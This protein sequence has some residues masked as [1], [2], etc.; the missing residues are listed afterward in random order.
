[1]ISIFIGA[2]KFAPPAKGEQ[3][4]PYDLWDGI[5]GNG[6]WGT[7]ADWWIEPGDNIFHENKTI[8]VNGNLYVNGS[9]TLTNVTLQMR[10]ATYDG[11]YNI[12]VLESGDLVI[13]DYDD[14]RDTASDAS[15]VES[16]TAFRFGFQAYPGS[17]LEFKNSELYDCGWTAPYADGL[18]L[19]IYTD[20]ANVTGNYINDSYYGTVIWYS[21]NV[22]L[23]NNT[24]DGPYNGVYTD[25]ANDCYL[26]NN[27]VT[28]I[29]NL[30]FFIYN[31]TML[32]L[33]YNDII[34][35][36]NAY[37][38]LVRGGGGHWIYN[39]TFSDNDLGVFLYADATT[40]T[41]TTSWCA[42][43]DNSITNNNYGVYIRGLNGDSAIQYIY[44]YDNDIYS[45]TEGVHIRGEAETLSVENIVHNISIYN[46]N[47]YSNS[48]YGMYL[49][50]Y[51]GPNV[52]NRVHIFENLVYDNGGNGGH[53]I[54]FTVGMYFGDVSYIYCWDNEVRDNHNGALN[55][56]AGYYLNAVSNIYFWDDHIADNDRNLWVVSSDNVYATNT[57]LD[58]GSG[59][60]DIDIRIDDRYGNPPSVYFL[61]TSFDNS[62]ADVYNAGSFLNVQWYLHVRVMQ[63][64]SGVD[65]ADVFINDSF[66]LPEPRFGQPLSTGTG[67]DGWIRWIEVTEFNRT[68][69]ATTR[70]TPHHID[71]VSLPSSSYADPS[72]NMSKEVIIYLNSPPTADNISST[73][74]IVYRGQEINITANGSDPEDSE[75]SLIAYF[76]YNDPNVPDWNTTYLGSAIY[77]GTPPSGFWQINFTPAGNAPLGL[78]EFRVRFEDPNGSLS[79]WIIAILATVVGNPPIANAGSDDTI[80]AGTSHTFDG[81]GS[82]DDE[83][84]VNYTWNFTYNSMDT[85]LYGIN[86]QFTFGIPGVY[87]VTLKVIDAQGEWDS[88]T[89]QIT[90]IDDIPPIVDAGQDASVKVNTPQDFDASGSW[91]NVGIVWYNWTFDDGSYDN[92]TNITLTHTFTS[93]GTYAVTL[94]CSDAYGNWAVAIVNITVIPSD[95]PIAEAGPDN[96]TDEDSFIVFNGSL[97]WDDFGIVNYYWDMDASDGLDWVTPDRT[98][99]EVSWMYDTPGIYIVTLRVIDGD[100]GFDLDTLNVTVFDIEPP[101]ANAGSTATIDEKTPY[102]FNGSLSTDNSGS[103]A[104]YNW[105]FG[106]GNYSNGTDPKPFHTY[107][108]PGFY[109]VTLNVSDAAGN[110]DTDTVWITVL[111]ITSPTANAGPDNTTNEK[112]PISFDG[113]AS[114]DNYDAPEMLSYKWDMDDSDGV[115]W[116]TPDRTGP[117]PIHVYFEPGNYT[118]TLNVTDTAGNSGLDTLWVW[119]F[120]ITPPTANAGPD[121]TVNEDSS[122]TFDG[123]GSSDNVGIFTYAWD[124]DGSDGVDWSSPDYWGVGPSHIYSDP[125]TY[126]A[127]LNVTDLAG[128]WS[129]D[130]VIINVTDITSP[131]ASAGPLDYDTVYNGTQ[132][133][134]NGSLSTDNSG[135]IAFYNWS[136]GDGS[137]TN[138]TDAKPVHIYTEPGIYIVTLK[139][140]D[141]AGN[142]NTDTMTIEVID[143]SSPKANAGSDATVDEDTPYTFDGSNSYDDVGIVWYAWDM[144]D[145]DGVDWNNPDHSDPNLWDPTHTY[146]EPGKYTVTLNVTDAEGNWDTDTMVINVTDIT[147]PIADAGPNAT[148][149]EDLPY[150]FD[151]SSSYDNVGIISYAWDMDYSD[152]LDW[153]SPNHTGPTPVHEYDTPGNYTITLNVTDAAGNWALDTLWVEV[154]DVSPPTA[155]AGPNAQINEDT[156]YTFDATGSTDNVGIVS[157]AWDV[158]VSD[159]IDWSKPDSSGA[160]PMHIYYQPGIYTVTLNLTDAAGNCAIA[161][162]SMEILDITP[163]TAEAGPN[164]QV[165]EDSP[166]T[167]N[168]S[169]SND[170][171]GIVSYAWD[172]DDSDGVDWSDPDYVG[173]T[174]MHV[175]SQPGVYTVTLNVT[176]AAGNCAIATLWVEVLDITPPITDAGPNAQVNEDTPYTFDASGSTDNVGIVS[177]AWDIDDSDGIDWDNPDYTLI[178]PTHIFAE[179]G[180]YMVTLRTADAKGNW[181]IDTVAI[182]VHDVTKPKAI[183]HYTQIMDEDVEYEF[184]ASVSTDNSGIATYNFSF[185][186]GLYKSGPEPIVTYTYEEPGVYQVTLNVTDI[187]GNFAFI[188]WDVKVLDTTP[189]LKPSGLRVSKVSTGGALNISWLPNTEEDLNHYELYFSD[190]GIDFEKLEDFSTEISSY[191]HSDLLNGK[192]YSYYL[193]AVDNSALSSEPS[194]VVSGVPDKNSDGDLDFDSEDD[195][196]DNDGVKDDVDEFPYDPLEWSDNDGDGVG[197]NTDEDDDEDGVLDVNDDLPF[198]PTE[199]LDTDG[200]GIGNNKDKDDDD[201]GKP[202]VSDDYPLDPEK[203]KAPFDFG[204]ILFILLAL[205]ATVV[206]IILGLLLFKQKRMNQELVQRIDKLEQAKT[207]PQQSRVPSASRPPKVQEKQPT[208]PVSTPT[209]KRQQVKLP[210]PPT[211]EQSPQPEKEGKKPQPPPPP[212]E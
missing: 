62:S 31:S 1:M 194:N 137:Y 53:G 98:G 88:D 172:I 128:Y 171:V 95:P 190:D 129:T 143:I 97:S 83:G 68:S 191:F 9:L 11:E 87:V 133:A 170:N 115:D 202:D 118:V 4:A 76:E 176:D 71:A 119:V 75:D 175:Y 157:Y 54:N 17:Q 37:G 74:F 208:S 99:M 80:S 72:M 29:E 44:I 23:A 22:M 210:P 70:Y 134:F 141:G 10:N 124:I 73:S 15:K 107:L 109:L 138:G 173:P 91:D 181:N 142:I 199:T 106:D 36:P 103:I 34:N 197:D 145:K 116:V 20:W 152:G 12:T 61:N 27:T 52:V 114:F 168:A 58:K 155:E 14:D 93:T 81:S 211:P 96:S 167:F 122:Y 7:D 84:I 6:I 67:N 13:Q 148:V 209:P 204:T 120:D 206:A 30:G 160:T 21:E 105:N 8:I 65:N 5:P 193:V 165:N 42:I 66:G 195:D 77:I 55:T 25:H 164:V 43:N 79:G 117:K 56:G 47:I 182:K 127:T 192:N 180:T 166:F 16:I 156:P 90:V 59:A 131:I 149:N 162:L 35:N 45:N 63:F 104:L 178:S 179:P 196:D 151:G 147:A 207:Q 161:T 125:G 38:I 139:V 40:E 85:Y 108:K 126:I 41:K 78:Y 159:G 185:G 51:N 188:L 57:T 33:S 19:F 111:D 158:N 18:G 94:N 100:G 136:F 144:D 2:V 130:T 198:D 89:V 32:N 49:Y 153:S 203:W 86:P 26:G 186:D 48:D 140:T 3:G 102:M 123:S 177:H 189:P 200:D 50:G 113:S 24:I 201:D 187:A 112:S 101:T 183:V 169:G 82:T 39:N 69:T 46:N 154:L 92:G 150:N 135:S 184:N 121:G 60:G 132:Y 205:I 28:N 174:P 146:T 110:W 64:G 163:P 212:P